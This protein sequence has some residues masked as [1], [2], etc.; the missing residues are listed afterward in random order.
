MRKVISLLLFSLVLSAGLFLD[1]API[2]V[3]DGID[4]IYHFT[5]FFTIT[6]LSVF[7]FISFFNKK[8]LNS[9]LVLA[10][11]SGGAAAALSEYVQKSCPM[12]SCDSN[13][14]I[15]DLCGIA[16][17]TAIVYMINFKHLRQIELLDE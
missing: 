1:T 8:W 12:R 3:P 6:I 7:V 10:L 5:G 13:D 11:L 15:A 2:S 16:L 14:W 4:K 9:Y 17:A